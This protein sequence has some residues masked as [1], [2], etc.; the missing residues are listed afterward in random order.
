MA[1]ALTKG[2]EDKHTGMQGCPGIGIAYTTHPKWSEWRTNRSA[3][4]VGR[5]WRKPFFFNFSIFKSLGFRDPPPA[6]P[7]S[8]KSSGDHR[9][10]VSFLF[11]P[12]LMCGVCYPN[13]GAPLHPGMFIFVSLRQCSSHL[14]LSASTHFIVRALSACVIICTLPHLGILWFSFV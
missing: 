2:H 5:F 12:F 8:F 14:L 10:P 11:W 7:L 1:A 9:P 13:P 3:V 4:I 6:L